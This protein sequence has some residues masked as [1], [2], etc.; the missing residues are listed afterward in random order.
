VARRRA[1]QEIGGGPLSHFVTDGSETVGIGRDDRGTSATEKPD[2]IILFGNG[3]SR[4]ESPS[5][6][7]TPGHPKK[8]CPYFIGFFGALDCIF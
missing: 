8:I 4:L 2:S 6:G 1:V 5:L 3:R 7:S